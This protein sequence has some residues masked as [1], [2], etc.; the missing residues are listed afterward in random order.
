MDVRQTNPLNWVRTKVLNV[1]RVRIGESI[2]NKG[3][4]IYWVTSLFHEKKKTPTISTSIYSNHVP[5]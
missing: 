4:S 2:V 1:H 3:T 5:L